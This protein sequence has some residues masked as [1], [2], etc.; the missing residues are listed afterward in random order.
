M[1]NYE[2]IETLLSIFIILMYCL[3]PVNAFEIF[4]HEIGGD[5]IG[6]A[7][8]GAA[9]TAGI[10]AAVAITAPVSIPAAGIAAIALGCGIGGGIL[11]DLAYRKVT[12]K[13]DNGAVVTGGKDVSKDELINDT[14]VKNT[15]ANLQ[16]YSDAEAAKDLFAL[17]Q[18]LSSSLTTYDYESS[19]S[20]ADVQ[21]SIRGP[22]KVYGFTAFPLQVHIHAS[23]PADPPENCVHINEVK[24]YILDDSG[25][26]WW[27][28]EW[29]GDVEL[30]PKSD[31]YP[32]ASED[33]TLNFTLKTP[34]PYYGKAKLMATGTPN[35]KI[36]DE[37]LNANITKFEV[38]VEVNGYREVWRWE[39]V[40]DDEGHII[41]KKAEHV[42]DIPI[43][44]ELK[45]LSAYNHLQNGKY[46]ISGTTGSLPAKFAGE[47][48]YTAY[49]EWANGATSLLVTRCWATPVHVF[50]STADYKF[51]IIANLDYM[52]PIEAS[53][54]DDYRMV[55][56]RTFSDGTAAIAS[57]VPG[58]FGDMSVL[59]QV[60]SSLYYKHDNKTVG[61]D[62]YFV[63]YAT[64]HVKDDGSI[65]EF[66]LWLV[67]K[68]Q[69]SVLIN[70]DVVLSD[71]QT[72]EIAKIIDD[73]KVTE[74]EAQSL[75]NIADSAI[76]QLKQKKY[77]AEALANKYAN[78]PKAKEYAEKAAEYYQKAIDYLE[79]MKNSNDANEIAKYYKIAKNYEMVGDYY[80]DAA[81]KEYYGQHDQA[82][83]DIK[84]V[85]KLIEDTKQYEPSIW[86][87][88]GS[89]L[90]QVWQQFKSG[91]GLGAIPDW[92]L[93]LV[94]VILVIGGAIIVLKLF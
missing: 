81:Q 32:D 61:Y 92:V 93:I 90:G 76:S 64:L 36:L 48:Q 20:L 45:S 67:I 40:Y 85:E 19:G 78:N 91:L 87:S 71:K 75:K 35:K 49:A 62:T 42:E 41:D 23:V 83:A 28:N 89:T 29:S 74:Q 12:G 77:S 57:Q 88:A 9:V 5:D 7:I 54:F 34:D 94:V 65:D 1:M 39:Y 46:Y 72:E 69:I 2:R 79:D 86:F 17:R 16:A 13:D 22:S 30:R 6:V 68:P 18:K 56:F 43:N 82:E 26:K 10:V 53:I 51:A 63:L 25:K 66:P 8:A 84:N 3:A 15:L 60:G 52:K 70:K 24:V 50:D 47:R 27:V 59:N 73:G 33:L 38:V 80:Y 11:A 55:V 58:S 31:E 21:V 37:L 14:D 4:G 44:A